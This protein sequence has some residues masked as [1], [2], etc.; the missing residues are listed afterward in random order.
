METPSRKSRRFRS[1]SEQ[2][3]EAV[4]R[5]KVELAPIAA[6]EGD[7]SEPIIVLGVWIFGCSSG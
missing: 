7:V 1:T 3:V 2:G 6:D 4:Q 5:F